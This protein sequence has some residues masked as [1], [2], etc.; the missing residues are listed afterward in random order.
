MNPADQGETSEF[1]FRTKGTS[2]RWFDPVTGTGR[3]LTDFEKSE[4]RVNVKLQFAPRQSGFI[5]FTNEPQKD[6]SSGGNFAE[7]RTLLELDGSWD[8]SFYPEWGGPAKITFPELTDW[9]KHA[10]DGIKYY[11]GRAS[12]VKTFTMQEVQEGQKYVLDLGTVKNLA[13]VT[14]NGK[15]LGTV[16]CAPWHMKIEPEQGENTL[17]IEVVNLWVN[18]LIG[19]EKFDGSVEY[20]KGG[21]SH[22]LPEWLNGSVPRPEDRY[23]YAL[24]NS[25]KADSP[26]QPSGLLGPVLIKHLQ[27]D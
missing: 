27:N 14:L 10:N 16:W 4:G 2:P 25:W 24:Y 3:M 7:Y 5:Y 26:L 8:V 21:N 23:T 22:F 15:K 18:R 11:S 17:E 20:D 6:S 12:Y 19:D 1:S 13:N 9:S